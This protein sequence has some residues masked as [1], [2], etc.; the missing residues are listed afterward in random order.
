[1][2]LNTGTMWA[3]SELQLNNG[4]KKVLKNLSG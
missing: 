4:I 1:M 3:F 2:E